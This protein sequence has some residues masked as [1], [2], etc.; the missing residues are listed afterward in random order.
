MMTYFGGNRLERKETPRGQECGGQESIQVT[1]EK[2]A[3]LF[4]RDARC[5]TQ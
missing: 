4:L 3:S 5:T 2:Y 1:A